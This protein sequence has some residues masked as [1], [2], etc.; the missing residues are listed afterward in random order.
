M[1]HVHRKMYSLEEG[2]GEGHIEEEGDRSCKGQGAS[3]EEDIRIEENSQGQQ[4]TL[5][6]WK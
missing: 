3:I 1:Q 6:Q 4:G 5:M 2:L